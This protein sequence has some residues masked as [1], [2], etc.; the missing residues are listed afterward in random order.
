M[1]RSS[2]LLDHSCLYGGRAPQGSWMESRVSRQGVLVCTAFRA[3][4][5]RDLWLP[6]TDFSGQHFDDSDNIGPGV[7]QARLVQG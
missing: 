1:H 2:I 4:M 3:G 5:L 6:L 7:F